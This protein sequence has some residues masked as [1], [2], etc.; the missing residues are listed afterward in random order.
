MA[1][2]DDEGGGGFGAALGRPRAS[3]REDSQVASP[4]ARRDGSKK[5]GRCALILYLLIC[6]M[7]RSAV[8]SSC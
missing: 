7:I 5:T 6:Y 1:F 8:G 2:L 4:P 3:S